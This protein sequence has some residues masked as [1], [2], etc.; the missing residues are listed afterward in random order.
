[1]HPKIES[2]FLIPVLTLLC[3]D[4]FQFEF[5]AAYLV[6]TYRNATTA[7]RSLP[8]YPVSLATQRDTVGLARDE[9]KM[10]AAFVAFYSNIDVTHVFVQR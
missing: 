8:L 7:G 10:A 5:S 6:R 2:D 9:C 3:F 4:S 1:M